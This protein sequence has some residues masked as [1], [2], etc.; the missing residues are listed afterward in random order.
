VF[1]ISKHETMRWCRSKTIL[2]SS[3][4]V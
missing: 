2:I 4:C 3:P 1:P